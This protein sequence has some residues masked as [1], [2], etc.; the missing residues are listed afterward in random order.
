MKI[1]VIGCGIAGS[2]LSFFL[3][4]RGVDVLALSRVKKY[5]SI[6]LIQSLMQKHQ[7]DI[8]AAKRSREIYVEISRMFNIDNAISYVKSYTVI[9]KSKEEF[10][11]KLVEEWKRNGADVRKL[12]EDDLR[13]IPF[14]YYED[15]VLYLCNNDAIVRI[16]LIVERL[17]KEVGVRRCNVSLAMKNGKIRLYVNNKEV[18]NNFDMVVVC[19]GAWTRKVLQNINIRIPLISYKCQAGVFALST[20]ESDYILYDYVNKIYVRPCGK[21]SRASLRGERLM[22]AGNGNTPPMDPEE[23]AKVEPWFADD[24]IPKLLRRYEKARFVKGSAGFCDT[25]PD[26]RPIIGLIGNVLVVSG[27]DG[28][29]A[30]I[31]PAVAEIACKIILGEPL[32]ELEKTFLL[33]RF[34][35]ETPLRLPH[36]E[37]HEL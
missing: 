22:V 33:D 8:Y 36:V 15:E 20:R 27:F 7:A 1:C 12:S 18:D 2:F 10:V 11:D 26:S 21:L 6:G 4:M 5:P 35:E 16:D 29:G 3:K 24:I 14:K 17:W 37:A 9:P 32:D 25:T 19:C 23:K 34:S 31:G 30:E 13:E 28:Y